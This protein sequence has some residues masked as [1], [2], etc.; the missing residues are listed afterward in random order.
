VPLLEEMGKGDI[1]V[2]LGIEAI[3]QS[4]LAAKS[5]PVL[6]DLFSGG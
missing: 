2:P 3:S 5:V 1:C 6:M 4:L